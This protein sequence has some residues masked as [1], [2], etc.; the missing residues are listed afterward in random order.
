MQTVLFASCPDYINLNNASTLSLLQTNH[1]CLDGGGG[2]IRHPNGVIEMIPKSPAFV[3]GE[4]VRPAIDASITSFKY[5]WEVMNVGFSSLNGVFKRIFNPI[6]GAQAVQQVEKNISDQSLHQKV[7]H[8]I[9]NET[10]PLMATWLSFIDLMCKNQGGGITITPMRSHDMNPQSG[11]VV[12][13]RGFSKIVPGLE[14]CSGGRIIVEQYV[15]KNSELLSEGVLSE[16][17]TLQPYLGAWYDSD[18]AKVYLDISVVFNEE[19]ADKAIRFAKEQNQIA[20]YH[21]SEGREIPIGGTGE[22]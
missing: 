8:V 6:P 11:I 2:L 15:E 9:K 14:F 16:I 19:D 13:L 22:N 5:A 17:K 7:T 21:I 18:H 1:S 12:A 20:A 10:C 3:F 4:F